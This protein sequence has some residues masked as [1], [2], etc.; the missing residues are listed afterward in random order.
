[1][2]I[3]FFCFV[4][5]SQG[6]SSSLY[7][8]LQ[9]VFF[10]WLVSF[11]FILAKKTKIDHHRH[12][13]NMF[14]VVLLKSSFCLISA[15][16]CVCYGQISTNNDAI[17]MDAVNT[18]FCCCCCCWMNKKFQFINSNLFKSIDFLLKWW[19]N[20]NIDNSDIIE[21]YHDFFYYLSSKMD[22]E[23]N[24]QLIAIQ[25]SIVQYWLIGN[26]ILFFPFSKFIK[27]T[28]C[29][30]WADPLFNSDHNN[31][32]FFLRWWSNEIF[33]DYRS[34]THTNE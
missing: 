16:V 19:S 27:K 29:I 25:I 33:I 20:N 14:F 28:K 24:F 8:F 7:F 2:L 12:L 21:I 32:T 5:R 22:S 11:H 15:C 31:L 26:R 4:S 13:H 30:H 10:V 1:M 9:Y 23:H 18:I 3:S 17:V 6:S 34:H